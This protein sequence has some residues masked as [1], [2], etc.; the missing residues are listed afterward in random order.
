MAMRAPA[1]PAAQT[2][3]PAPMVRIVRKSRIR[4][5]MEQTLMIIGLASM[6][7]IVLKAVVRNLPTAIFNPEFVDVMFT[8]LLRTEA[9]LVLASVFFFTLV[10][11]TMLLRVLVR[12]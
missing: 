6:L 8:Y 1:A 4:W 7:E 12:R 10:I 2:P 3:T 11:L 5:F 9:W